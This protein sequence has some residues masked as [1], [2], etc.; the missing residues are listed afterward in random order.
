MK[1]GFDI[2]ADVKSLV[3]VPVITG[4][5]ESPIWEHSRPDNSDKIELVVNSLGATNDQYQKGFANINIYA[6]SLE[7]NVGGKVSRYAN[8]PVLNN[9]VKLIKPLVEKQFRP[10]FNTEIDE[11]PTLMQDTD[12]SWF[13]NIRLKY[14]SIK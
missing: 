3:N 4:A 5:I 8:T 13:V 2:V 10:T 9:L 12:G 1:D 6:P 11:S 7:R 14:R